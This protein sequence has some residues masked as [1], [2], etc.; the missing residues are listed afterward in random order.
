MKK[1]LTPKS[2]IAVY[3]SMILPLYDVGDIFYDSAN[4]AY[5]NKLQILQNRAVRVLLQLPCRQNTDEAHSKL[6]LMKLKSR[7]KLH[8]IQIAHWMAHQNKYWDLRIL[9]TR[10]HAEGRKS[11]TQNTG[12]AFQRI[13]TS[14]QK[15]PRISKSS[16]N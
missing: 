5:L 16:R 3:K 15:Q 12:T 4:A 2:I 1:C 11:I 6:N 13:Y 7:R 10:A 8:M 9:K 14:L